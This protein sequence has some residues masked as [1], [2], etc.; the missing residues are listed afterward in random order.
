[1]KRLK[2][3]L[4]NFAIIWGLQIGWNVACNMWMASQLQ[5]W[6]SFTHNLQQPLTWASLIFGGLLWVFV[7]SLMALSDKTWIVF[8]VVILQAFGNMSIAY[9]QVDEVKQR[10]LK[11]HW[12][13]L[14]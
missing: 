4:G 11:E 5:L 12:E 13:G 6:D 7:G 2:V 14:R 10:Q 9:E 3:W 1:M 8:T